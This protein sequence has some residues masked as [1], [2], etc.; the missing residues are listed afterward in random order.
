MVL[1][2]WIASNEAYKRLGEIHC[3]WVEVSSEDLLG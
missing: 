1:C 3:K 2:P